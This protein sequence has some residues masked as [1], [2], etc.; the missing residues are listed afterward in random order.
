MRGKE[1]RRGTGAE[2]WLRPSWVMAEHV[3]VVLLPPSSF[4]S[5]SFSRL[6]KNFTKRNFI[7][8]SHPTPVFARHATAG[9]PH[10]G[11]NSNNYISI[12]FSF[13]FRKVAQAVWRRT[14]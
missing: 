8:P 6:V 1:S 13:V 12:A 11:S 7:F 2:R 3:M 4:F 10:P 9:L 5:I 14:E